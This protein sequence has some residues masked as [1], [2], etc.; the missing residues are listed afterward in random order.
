MPIRTCE[1]PPAGEAGGPGN[2]DCLAAIGSKNSPNAP[3]AQARRVVKAKLELL[4][5]AVLEAGTAAR[6]HLD[7][8][9]G[10]TEVEDDAAARH[11]G[12]RAVVHVREVARCLND[13]AALRNG[14]PMT[15][16][17]IFDA[18]G[19]L[20]GS[21]KP[22]GSGWKAL[23]LDGR[24]LGTFDSRIEAVLTVLDAARDPGR[25]EARLLAAIEAKLRGVSA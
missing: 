9:I 23:D 17:R 19:E 1:S 20:V 18:D 13:V 12:G 3:S 15:G 5:E 2:V 24:R 25:A 7:L 22:H 10:S 21:I 6:I 16:S 4:R 14:R 11:H 8:M